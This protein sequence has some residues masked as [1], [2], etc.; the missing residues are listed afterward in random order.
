MIFVSSFVREFLG[1]DVGHFLS[2]DRGLTEA[3]FLVIEH[4]S[5]SPE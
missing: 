1:N 2:Q 3:R 4:N 5:S